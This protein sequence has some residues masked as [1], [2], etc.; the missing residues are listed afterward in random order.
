MA[1]RQDARVD[2][3][4]EKVHDDFMMWAV[5]FVLLGYST[6]SFGQS[7]ISAHS[8]VV[9]YVEG[10]VTI[11]NQPVHPKFAQFPELKTD[12]VI[13]TD[14][15]RVELLLTPGV[16]LRLSEN[17]SVRMLSNSLSDT[18]LAVVSGSALI[19][20]G[21]LLPNNSITFEAAGTQIAL[22]HKGLYRI[23]A[24]SNRLRVYDGQARVTAGDNQALVRKGHEVALNS[25][26]LTQTAFDIKDTDAFY[27]WSARRS[28]YVADANITSARVANNP[29]STGY[30]SSLGNG[31]PN[32]AWSWNPW[33]GMFTYLPGG[34]GMYMSPFGSAY[35][36][37]I[38][39][40][41]LYIPRAAP[42]AVGAAGLRTASS[43]SAAPALGMRTAPAAAMRSAPS[44]A[45]RSSRR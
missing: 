1:N 33:F 36:S 31:S 26:T 12:Q 38:M 7:V 17:S 19:E 5:L 15:G 42:L 45:M 27:R 28:E 34:D 39:A 24:D 41:G 30:V 20:I 8:G 18:R 9:Q 13:A 4:F 37:P 23:D 22:P 21:E 2:A 16:F 43:L 32:G 10:D 3:G 25:S 35:Y 40:T 44:V 14:E 11:D 29:G 6:L